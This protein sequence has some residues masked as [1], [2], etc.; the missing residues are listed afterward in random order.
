MSKQF[1]FVVI[2]MFLYALQLNA[3]TAE[4]LDR[5]AERGERYVRSI[6]KMRQTSGDV[7]GAQ[8]LEQL[9]AQRFS[10]G[11]RLAAGEIAL[12]AAPE[13]LSYIAVSKEIAQQY[14]EKG[15]SGLAPIA[16]EGGVTLSHLAPTDLQQA[17]KPPELGGGTW[18]WHTK[19]GKWV[20][21]SSEP[22]AIEKPVAPTPAPVPEPPAK[23]I[24]VIKPPAPQLPE[25]PPAAPTKPT[26]PE[27]P[28]APLE[29]KPAVIVG[30]PEAPPLPVAP[31]VP[32]APPVVNPAVPLAPPIVGNVPGAPPAPPVPGA[33]P[34]PGAPAAPAAPP[35]PGAPPVLGV[36]NAG[37]A[38]AKPA[39]KK[40]LMQEE[41]AALS[42]DKKQL[43][44]QIYTD[45][46]AK[47]SKQFPPKELNTSGYSTMVRDAVKKLKTISGF[48]R[49][50]TVS[51]G[52]S[53]EETAQTLDNLDANIK[54]FFDD[55]AFND[56]DNMLKNF[57]NIKKKAIDLFKS[58]LLNAPTQEFNDAV[59]RLVIGGF[60][61]A[62]M[63]AQ[64]AAKKKFGQNEQIISD[65]VA[66]GAVKEADAVDSLRKAMLRLIIDPRFVHYEPLLKS[67]AYDPAE[68][69]GSIEQLKIN[70]GSGT[71]L[72]VL[73]DEPT[74]IKLKPSVLSLNV[75]NNLFYEPFNAQDELSKTAMDHLNSIIEQYKKQVEERSR[76]AAPVQET[77]AGEVNLDN[78]LKAMWPQI[79]NLIE[80]KNSL[81]A[82][83]KKRA[84]GWGQK[85]IISIIDWLQDD[86]QGPIRTKFFRIFKD[87]TNQEK[88]DQ[89]YESMK[90]YVDVLAAMKIAQDVAIAR[91]EE[92]NKL[93][94]KGG[95]ENEAQAFLIRQEVF[96]GA[97]LYAE[98]NKIFKKYY[99]DTYFMFNHVLDDSIAWNLPAIDK[100]AKSINALPDKTEGERDLKQRLTNRV[101]LLRSTVANARNNSLQQ[102][103]TSLYRTVDDVYGAFSEFFTKGYISSFSKLGFDKT[104]FLM[105]L[106]PYG[107]VL[108]I[109]SEFNAAQPTV[110][111]YTMLL[112]SLEALDK[113]TPV[114]ILANKKDEYFPAI[115]TAR[116]EIAPPTSLYKGRLTEMIKGLKESNFVVVKQQ[117]DQ[118]VAKAGVGIEEK[119]EYKKL[120]DTF[121]PQLLNIFRANIIEIV[122]SLNQGTRALDLTTAS[123][124]FKSKVSVVQAY[125]GQALIG[126]LTP[127][128][129]SIQSK[130]NIE[131]LDFATLDAEIGKVRDTLHNAVV[132]GLQK[133]GE[134]LSEEQVKA[135]VTLIVDKEIMAVRQR[136]ADLY[137]MVTG[138]VA[139]S[140]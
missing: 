60:G 120:L 47:V 93:D 13:G 99:W 69:I 53:G 70:A 23:P 16:Q 84:S 108:K 128:I 94:A 28:A 27:T 51:K 9:L 56:F 131:D 40:L 43:S 6:L 96:K 14:K 139:P 137:K 76:L 7:Q 62:R 106:E 87:K 121:R 110:E 105:I 97:W 80:F 112:K 42:A 85:T 119:P 75:W 79:T 89:L 65:N 63:A 130:K 118:L 2:S 92:A 101:T 114:N 20:F 24:E 125:V 18:W 71:A 1:F 138:K 5:F 11:A 37:Q 35:I 61:V 133:A 44:D 19:L 90:V 58:V 77:A 57:E 10:G 67:W 113:S 81:Q 111:N 82:L 48:V 115:S 26:A 122:E 64:E 102:V 4:E 100:L 129:E 29:P 73:A 132:Q 15:L 117:V 135:I 39:V 116:Q 38:S 33:P 86:P 49:T 123:V 103:F 21:V 68:K 54:A 59:E 98:L 109:I 46:I 30:V 41:A 72:K 52:R 134:Q 83:S 136:L 88:F 34:I 104:Y 8:Q 126:V 78:E 17:Q 31:P 25:P 127:L 32:E 12:Q 95:K 3:Y 36:P 91:R 55:K 74:V 22:F 140:V 124:A 66:F 50:E 107:L 45:L